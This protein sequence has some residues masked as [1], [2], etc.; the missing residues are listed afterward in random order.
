[1]DQGGICEGTKGG[2]CRDKSRGSVATKWGFK[3]L[4]QHLKALGS[5]L[6]LLVER[7]RY[8]S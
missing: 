2:R 8:Y 1:M 3:F 5:N 6:T 7:N 4:F